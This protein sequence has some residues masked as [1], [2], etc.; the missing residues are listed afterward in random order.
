MRRRGTFNP[1]FPCIN[2]GHR[3]LRARLVA[4]NVVVCPQ[5]ILLDDP[6]AD[7]VRV[8]D[9]QEALCILCFTVGQDVFPFDFFIE[10]GANGLLRQSKQYHRGLKFRVD[11]K[12]GSRTD[13]AAKQTG[14]DQADYFFTLKIKH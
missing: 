6:S 11:Q 12:R 9:L 1:Y 13:Q 14:D 3:G 2:F 5:V 4:V 10:L 8:Q 7:A